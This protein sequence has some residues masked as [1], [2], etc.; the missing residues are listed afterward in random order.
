MPHAT[1]KLLAGVDVNRTPA[2]NEAC[3]SS[4]NLI[5]FTS[6]REGLSLVQKRGGWDRYYPTAMSSIPRALWAWEDTNAN[7]YLAVGCETSATPGEGAPLVA[8]NDDNAKTISPQT[9]DS[10]V[11]PELTTTTTS[12]VVTVTDTG[13]NITSYDSV[14]IPTHISVGG[15]IVFGFFRCT[16]ASADTYTISLFNQIG[17]PI[18]PAAAETDQGVVAVFDTTSASAI[19]EVT[20]PDH[21]FAVG[22]TY[23]ILV[24]TDVGGITLFGNYIVQSVSD[25]DTFTIAA[26]TEATATETVSINGGNARYLYYVSDGPPPTG[27][28][29][30]VG[31]YG[32]GGY[33]SGTGIPPVFSGNAL[34]AS[35]WTLDNW[36]EILVACPSGLTF[37]PTNGDPIGG[38][39]Y[40]W[41][42]TANDPTASV[43]ATG[44]IANDGCFVAMPYRQIVAWGSTFTG[45]QDPLL[46]RWSDINSFTNWYANTTSQAG[47]YRISKGSRIISGIQGPQQGLIWTDLALWA[48]QYVGLE[49]GV[50]QFNEIGAGCGLIAKKAAG[51][52]NGTIY[53]MGQSQFFTLSGAGV[54]PLPCS[55]WDVIFQNLDMDNKHKIRIAPN[56]RFNEVEWYYP[57]LSGGG[58]VDSYVKLNVQLGV[59]DFG[60]LSRTAWINESVLGP[61]IGTGSDA[62]IY[63]HETSPDADGQALMA[64]F[65]TGYFTLQDGDLMTFVDQFF[66]DMK[67]GPYG[68]SP[69]ATV[70][71]IFNVADYAGATPRQYGPYTLTQAV[72]YITPR[73]RGRLVSL[74]FYSTDVGSFWRIG[75]N[76][77]RWAAAGKF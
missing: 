16:G 47:S 43:V 62:L 68:S 18:I 19:V 15:I 3:I 24:S 41:S 59:W 17:D 65:T 30:G 1:L 49:N 8:I 2:L 39:I 31:G 50:Y 57:S 56:S 37:G 64:T 53:W 45:I 5:R 73:F 23:P 66:P 32:T 21:G 72:T 27:S 69:N 22:D 63:Q 58:E 55:I 77:Y 74:T 33:G 28:G 25:A 54:Q 34:D 12:N 40:V 71:L 51:S 13:S 48:M 29:Y 7:T 14:F 46:I 60:S 42:P 75:A 9:E 11:T 44:P 35:D 4:C 67:W 26:A 70:F 38:P 61:P 6:D 36:G 76:R 52:L 10:D 20:L